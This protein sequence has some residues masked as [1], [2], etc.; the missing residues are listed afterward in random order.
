MQVKDLKHGDEVYA[1]LGKD[2]YS[3][4]IEM[5][6]VSQSPSKKEALY[7]CISG[8]TPIPLK[9]WQ[10]DF[11]QR[12]K[13]N[14]SFIKMIWSPVCIADGDH[15]TTLEYE[16]IKFLDAHDISHVAAENLYKQPFDLSKYSTIAFHTTGVYADKIKKL[17]QFDMDNLKTVVVLNE[18]AYQKAKTLA[19]F[20]G[21][22]LIGFNHVYWD[23]FQETGE[24]EDKV[25]FDPKGV[26]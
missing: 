7:V 10:G 4:R 21:I 2:K 5:R 25:L 1:I 26:W 16:F 15:F 13:L 8:R 20:L 24:F 3:A 11:Q 23:V 17:F 6:M 18:E 12:I 9:D 19:D 22:K 14:N